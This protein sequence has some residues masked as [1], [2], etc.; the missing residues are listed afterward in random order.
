MQKLSPAKKLF[1]VFLILFLSFSSIFIGYI[2]QFFGN[3]GGKVVL[4][5]K[6]QNNLNLDLSYNYFLIYFGYVGCESI[7]TPSLSEINRIYNSLPNNIQK[8]VKVYFVN[9]K[10]EIDKDL[11]DNFAK[12]FNKSFSGIYLD[13]NDLDIAAKDFN[14]QFSKVMLN[15]FEID[16]RGY[17]YIVKNSQ[18][19]LLLEN[20]YTNRPFDTKSISN[21]IK[22]LF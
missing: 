14:L 20:M 16:H 19:G 6:I 15:D 11:V 9:I 18:N 4:N 10:T 17:L 8:K 2:N 13:K 5:K 12:Y 7:C 3:S 22:N 21:D 1:G